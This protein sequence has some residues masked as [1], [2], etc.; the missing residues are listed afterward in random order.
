MQKKVTALFFIFTKFAK[1]KENRNCENKSKALILLTI[2]TGIYLGLDERYFYFVIQSY[3]VLSQLKF[4][5][6]K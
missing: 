1:C 3:V 2:S 4:K 5:K 6:K